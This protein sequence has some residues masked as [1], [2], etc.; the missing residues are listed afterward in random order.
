MMQDLR[1]AVGM[2][3]II[4]VATVLLAAHIAHGGVTVL[5]LGTLLA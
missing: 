5:G 3:G 1:A 4:F 2:G